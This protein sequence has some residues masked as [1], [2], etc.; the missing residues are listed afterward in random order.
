MVGFMLCFHWCA[1]FY[2]TNCVNLGFSFQNFYIFYVFVISKAHICSLKN[3]E[4]V[5]M[6]KNKHK[7][8]SMG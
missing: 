6:Y 5:V 4:N 1:P 2:V 7:K 3:R 8:P